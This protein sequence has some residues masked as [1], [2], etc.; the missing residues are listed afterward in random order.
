MAHKILQDYY[1]NGAIVYIDDI[2][3]YGSTVEGFLCILDQ[4]IKSRMAAYNVRLKP[5]NALSEC[6]PWN[7]WDIFSMKMGLG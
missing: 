3:I 6:S 1:L 2:M 5:S 7:F 4:S